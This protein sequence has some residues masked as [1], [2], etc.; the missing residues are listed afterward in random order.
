ML[1]LSSCNK[2]FDDEDVILTLL[3]LLLN[4][5]DNLKN[6]IEYG[7]DI[8]TKDLVIQSIKARDFNSKIKKQEGSSGKYYFE[9]GRTQNNKGF[10]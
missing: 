7:R 1:D 10:N 3:N 6:T 4:S 5:F 8:H 2:K 9:T